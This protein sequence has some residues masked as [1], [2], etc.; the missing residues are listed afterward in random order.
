VSDPVDQ[1]VAINLQIGREGKGKGRK[2]EEN[3]ALL[4][5]SSLGGRSNIKNCD[6]PLRPLGKRGG[7][8]R[9]KGHGAYKERLYHRMK[10]DGN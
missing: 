3:A 5:A 2:K 1:D 9:M 8:G 6:L 4:A 7:I 10:G